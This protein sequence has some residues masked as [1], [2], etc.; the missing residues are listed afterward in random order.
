[1]HQSDERI[2]QT[3]LEKT[4]RM[5]EALQARG[6]LSQ[7]S[8]KDHM[9]CRKNIIKKACKTLFRHGFFKILYQ[10][11]PF[12][13][14]MLAFYKKS[15]PAQKDQ[16]NIIMASVKLFA[17]QNATQNRLITALSAKTD[18]FKLVRLIFLATRPVALEAAD[19][20]QAKGWHSIVDVIFLLH[21][22]SFPACA[23]LRYHI[24]CEKY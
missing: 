23:L 2:R 13:D 8:H 6:N 12:S 21:I 14:K 18:R 24:R 10:M 4:W 17:V 9:L 3:T 15:S 7:V 22:E 19:D 11:R 16:Y 1:M 20:H 5:V